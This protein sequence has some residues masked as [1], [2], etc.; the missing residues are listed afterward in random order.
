MRCYTCLKIS[1]EC[2]RTRSGSV[3]AWRSTEPPP[4]V[5][6]E[7]SRPVLGG[8]LSQTPS[9]RTMKHKRFRING[10]RVK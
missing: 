4:E 7:T 10:V 6:V 3:L 1:C 8:T 2:I 9:T 5:V